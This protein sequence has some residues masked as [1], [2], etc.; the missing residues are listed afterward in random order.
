MLPLYPSIRPYQTHRIQVNDPHE[1]YVEECGN[2]QGIPVLVVHGGPGAG[3]GPFLRR[4]FDPEKFRIILYD[5]RGAGQSTPHA[6]IENNTTADLI[7]DM[8]AIRAH[9]AVEQWLL[10]GGSW[11]STLCLLYA[12]SFPETVMGLIVRGIFLARS[13]D[14]NW[15]YQHGASRIFPDHWSRFVAPIPESERDDLVAAYHKRLTGEDE[16]VRMSSAKAW[17]RW[18]GIT[19]T[20]E[21]RES[22]LR[23]FSDPHVALSLA[24]IETHYFINQAFLAENQILNEASRLHGIPGIIVHGRYDMIC[25]LDNAWALSRVWPDS[26]LWIIRDAGHSGSEPAIVDGLI[27]AVKEISKRIDS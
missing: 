21:P 14:L 1:L 13:Q 24:S 26:E 16:L 20:L 2:P 8:D 10:F 19:A 22:V 9:L 25:P 3:S 15:F 12:Q 5:Q 27:R 18:E 17:A 4:Y 11:G 23:K 7:K 6:C